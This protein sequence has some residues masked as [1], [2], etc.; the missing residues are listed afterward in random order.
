[1]KEIKSLP[2][3][4]LL[5]NKSGYIISCNK[6]ATI[7]F[8][9]PIIGK[10]VQIVISHNSNYKIYKTQ[11]GDNFIYFINSPARFGPFYEIIENYQN[12]IAISSPEGEIIYENNSFHSIS[13]LHNHT[14]SEILSMYSNNSITLNLVLKAKK[15][16][17]LKLT[18]ENCQWN[19]VL[20]PF[21]Q[22]DKNISHIL[23]S[24]NEIKD[25]T[26]ALTKLN[27]AKQELEAQ[28]KEITEQ[29]TYNPNIKLN[30]KQ[31]SDI[32]TLIDNMAPKDVTM[33]LLGKSGTGKSC[34]AKI[35]HTRSNRKNKPF[36]TINCSAIPDSLLE[37]E[38]F[39]YEKGAFTGALTSG[40]K[41][42]AEAAN[43]GT[44][45]L[46][47]IG[48]IPLSM[49]GKLLEL[50]QEKT[51]KPVGSISS[52]KIDIRIIAATNKDLFQLVKKGLFRE[53]L[54]YRIA[55]AV[56][57]IP[58]I[59]EHKEDIAPLITG[60]LQ[61]FNKKYN[62]RIY[63]TK[64]AMNAFIKYD[65]P[66]NI[67]ELEHLV[68]FLV[69]N[70]EENVLLTDLP[71]YLIHGEENLSASNMDISSANTLKEIL[72]Q[73]ESKVIQEAYKVH[74]SS[75]RVADALDISQSKANRLILKYCK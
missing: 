68:E 44:L 66:G 58:P 70:N 51:L 40:K 10:P 60:Y 50:I 46:D 52:K 54:Y 56:I 20:L 37:S 21:F 49:Q 17:S 32:Y 14:L 4:T 36:I 75:Y 39:G 71:Y 42:L 1:M 62:K 67:R 22:E 72:E 35:I 31:M 59:C 11:I 23:V 25:Y 53:D 57:N 48:E 8:N 3:A 64:D 30:S 33:L 13:A 34:F 47:E 6:F 26:H 73:T 18:I 65:W 63:F 15:R 69:I 5:V 38:I 29:N 28:K 16:L 2:I 43:G 61:H 55:V 45:F 12:P 9:D 27:T 19:M 74:K 24:C 7:L 41:G